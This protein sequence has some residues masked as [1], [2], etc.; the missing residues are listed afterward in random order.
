MQAIV[1]YQQY[2]HDRLMVTLLVDQSR[3]FAINQIT[4]FLRLGTLVSA[5]PSLSYFRISDLAFLFGAMTLPYCNAVASMFH[6]HQVGILVASG[7]HL[8]GNPSL[9]RT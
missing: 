8:T 3:V 9:R 5:E 7:A 6:P 1:S 2:N 4:P